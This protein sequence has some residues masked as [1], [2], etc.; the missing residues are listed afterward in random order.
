MGR[1]LV[2]VHKIK[3]IYT[4]PKTNTTLV[5]APQNPLFYTGG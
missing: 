1:E 5:D 3:F 2:T 4:L